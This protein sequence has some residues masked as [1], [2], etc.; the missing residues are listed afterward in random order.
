MSKQWLLA[1]VLVAISLMQ[2]SLLRAQDATSL[3]ATPE[4]TKVTVAPEQTLWRVAADNTPLG[5]SPWQVLIAIYKANPEAFKDGHI[6]QIISGST[7]RMPS[8]AA[9]KSRSAKAAEAAY[10]QLAKQAKT[11]SV[12]AA[13]PVVQPNVPAVVSKAEATP[14]PISQSTPSQ[15]LASLSQQMENLQQQLT[16]QQTK[17]QAL[18]ADIE[19]LQPLPAAPDPATTK[20]IEANSLAS[21]NISVQDIVSMLMSEQYYPWLVAVLCLLILVLLLVLILVLW[22]GLRRQPSADVKVQEPFLSE[23]VDTNY[24][25]TEM[26]SGAYGQQGP[27]DTDNKLNQAPYKAASEADFIAQLLQ[28]QETQA[29]HQTQSDV[30]LSAEVD[31]VLKQ[32][33]MTQNQHE[34]QQFSSNEDAVL[35]KLDLARSYS[36]MGHTDQARA[37]LQEVLHE[38]NLEQQTAATILLSELYQD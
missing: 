11:P 16:D 33:N 15:T 26:D 9:I 3:T 2:S 27:E 29:H 36:E 22:I 37:L 30:P 12:P 19:A 32:E 31:T 23:H 35:T 38:G 20:T 10:K 34:P 21:P 7:V 8:L 6:D 28:E 5:T 17:L 18:Y 14:L 25:D 13:N 24:K 1:I 4:A